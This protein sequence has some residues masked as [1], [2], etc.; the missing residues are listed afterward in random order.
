[1]TPIDPA[2]SAV[3]SPWQPGGFSLTVF[4]LAVT[5][6]VG[7]ILVLTRLVNP[8][9]PG[10]EKDRPYECGV[11]PT[12]APAFRYPAP[13]ALVAVVFL[14]FD[15]ETAFIYTWAVSFEA[16]DVISFVGMVGFIGVLLV[17]LWYLCLKGGLQWGMADRR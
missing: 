6:L 11:V 12:D 8:P 15:V 4:A 16:M 14:I 10:P 1:M 9:K 7:A 5:G 3:L 2:A 17:S 13:F